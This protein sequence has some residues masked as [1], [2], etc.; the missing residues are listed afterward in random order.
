[1]GILTMNAA[2]LT[3]API[4][5]TYLVLWLSERF[6]PTARDEPPRLCDREALG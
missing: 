3:L 6:P 4:L 2:L 5:L 1:M